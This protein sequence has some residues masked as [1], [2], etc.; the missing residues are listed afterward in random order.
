MEVD[1]LKNVHWNLMK[2]VEHVTII[3]MHFQLK[4]LHKWV[5]GFQVMEKINVCFMYFCFL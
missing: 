5:H 4:Q 3:H 2:S 1:F